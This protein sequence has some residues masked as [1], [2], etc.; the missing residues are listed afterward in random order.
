M[1]K[2]LYSGKEIEL[3]VDENFF[4]TLTFISPRSPQWELVR[5]L[6]YKADKVI[7]Y[8]KNLTAGF[9]NN[10][11]SIQLLVNICDI[12]SNW[13]T[14]HLFVNQ[15]KIGYIYSLRWL[16]CYLNSLQCHDKRAWCLTVMEVPK[17]IQFEASITIKID[18]E[19]IEEQVENITI[20][21]PCISPCKQISNY[22]WG[23][24]ELPTDIKYQFQAAAIEQ[25]YASCPNFNIDEFAPIFPTMDINSTAK[26]NKDNKIIEID[27]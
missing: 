4:A 24:R 25:G 6:C 20:K 7:E 2:S 26:E 11:K 22:R 19:N 27:K 10:K 16:S 13:K 15:R 9:L 5:Q 1:E 12:V 17:R 18:L 21:D 23:Y 3:I 14:V 8:K